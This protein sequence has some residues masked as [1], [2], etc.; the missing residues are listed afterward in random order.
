MLEMAHTPMTHNATP[1]PLADRC[2]MIEAANSVNNA[3]RSSRWRR[4][5]HLARTRDLI[6]CRSDAAYTCQLSLLIILNARN[7]PAPF[8]I[9]HSNSQLTIEVDLPRPSRLISFQE[10]IDRIGTK[11]CLP[12]QLNLLDAL[13]ERLTAA[14]RLL[15]TNNISFPVSIEQIALLQPSSSTPAST[16]SATLYLRYNKKATWA[17]NTWPP[18]WQD[19]QLANARWFV[20][21]AK[22]L[23]RL[24]LSSGPARLDIPSQQILATYLGQSPAAHHIDICSRAVA[25]MTEELAHEIALALVMRN[26]ARECCD[27]LESFF[28]GSMA[29]PKTSTSPRNMYSSFSQLRAHALDL[30]HH[31]DTSRRGEDLD[32]EIPG[33]V[34]AATFTRL[35]CCRAEAATVL[36]EPDEPQWWRMAMA[37]HD[38]FLSGK[39]PISMPERICAFDLYRY[40][41]V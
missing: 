35:V 19:D 23:V 40:R 29:L 20:H 36:H 33:T 28:G 39:P 8:P 7:C 13:E 32:D 27:V 41:D 30:G 2:H 24:S 37:L 11:S 26:K 34:S 9:R 14:L 3:Q 1:M 17:S 5:V 16:E 38:T 4:S 22:L 25:P 31:S 12:I 10:F 6:R 18:N 15:H 21:I